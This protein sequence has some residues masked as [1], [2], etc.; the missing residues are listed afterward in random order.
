MLNL[1]ILQSID[2]EKID[3]KFLHCMKNIKTLLF[4]PVSFFTGKFKKTEYAKIL[5]KLEKKII[6][7]I[8]KIIQTHKSDWQKKNTIFKSYRKPTSGHATKKIYL[9]STCK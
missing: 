2:P 3:F 4:C 1:E 7:K 8:L 6:Y 9:L 5:I